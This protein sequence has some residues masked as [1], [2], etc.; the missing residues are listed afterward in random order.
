MSLHLQT[1]P[2]KTDAGKGS[3]GICR[4]VDPSGS[5]SAEPKIVKRGMEHPVTYD[6][7]DEALDRLVQDFEGRGIEFVQGLALSW[8]IDTPFDRFHDIAPQEFRNGLVVRDTSVTLLQG[9][10][11]L[12]DQYR[13]A[14]IWNTHAKRKTAGLISDILSG[15][16]L[17]PPW[18][19]F[20]RCTSSFYVHSGHNRFA[21]GF[22]NETGRLPILL[23]PDDAATYD[24]RIEQ[25]TGDNPH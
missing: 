20:D 3:N 16:A 10:V 2:A 9:L 18:L 23:T 8:D 1:K 21:I 24:K 6:H 22:V 13:P 11:G 7:D 25:G 12:P 14:N 19:V 17:T 15:K 5:L 4:V